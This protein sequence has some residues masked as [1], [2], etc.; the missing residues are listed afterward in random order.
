MISFGFS[1]RHWQQIGAGRPIT[2][3]RTL[4]GDCS[5]EDAGDGSS[6]GGKGK[7]PAHVG[8]IGEPGGIGLNSGSVGSKRVQLSFH[9]NFIEKPRRLGSESG[10]LVVYESINAKVSRLELP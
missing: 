1:A 7:E 4:T 2:V 9:P 10:A 8:I 5:R 3:H 6:T